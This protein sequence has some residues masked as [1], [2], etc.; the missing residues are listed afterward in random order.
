VVTS[1]K[2]GA[3][4]TATVTGNANAI[5]DVNLSAGST[6]AGVSRTTDNL[7]A[8]L[9]DQIKTDSDLM[10][11]GIK[12]YS[13]DPG[14]AGKI[15]FESSNDTNFRLNAVGGT[16]AAVTGSLTGA[17]PY[18]ITTGVNDQLT[19]AV[20]GGAAQTITLA[21]S[22]GESASALVADIQAKITA[23]PNGAAINAE[24][25]VGATA[26]GG[27]TFTSSATTGSQSSVTFSASASHDALAALGLSVGTTTGAGPDVGF[28][29]ANGSTFS[30]NVASGGASTFDVAGGNQLSTT[31]DGVNQAHALSFS[32]IAYGGDTQSVV[33]S[34]NNSTGVPQTLNV[35]LG[36]NATI[37]NASSLD[38][39]VATINNALQASNNATLQSIVAVKD[40]VNGAEEINFLSS[41]TTFSVTAAQTANGTGIGAGEVSTEQGVTQNAAQVGTGGTANVSNQASAESAVTAIANATTILGNSQSVAG[42]GENEFGYAANLAQSQLTNETAAESQ[43]R[44]ANLAQQ[45]AVLT[46]AQILLQAGI[47]ALAQANSAPQQL[48]TLLQGH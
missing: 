39:A 11:A 32:G 9:N 18:V 21:N 6:V 8:Y 37:R 12:A 41:G 24:L 20:N 28:G 14:N 30:D 2:V 43:I 42:I 46:K 47:A 34:A 15:Y 16:N 29:A 22:A 31:V 48:L 5:A 1:N 27:I 25:T 23:L 7:V 4:S 17:T 19:F 40:D 36:N 38:Q 13:T 3:G 44:D 45:S 10:A 35:T 26:N 33:I